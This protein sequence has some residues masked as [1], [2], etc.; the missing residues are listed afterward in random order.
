MA[1]A[2]TLPVS[3]VLLLLFV[4]PA[5]AAFLCYDEKYYP[6]VDQLEET[7]AGFVAHL[8]GRFLSSDNNTFSPLFERPTLIYTKEER[9]KK[10]EVASCR[11]YGCFEEKTRGATNLPPVTLSREEAIALRPV[12][13]NALEIEQKVTASIEY[14]ELIWFG[15][16]FYSGEGTSGVGGVGRYDPTTKTLEIRRPPLLRDS[17]VRPILHDGK[18][19]WLGTFGAYECIG[20]PPKHGLVRYVWDT[21]QLES[22]EG[23]EDGPCGYMVHDLLLQ[24][25]RLWVAT[26]L[27]LSR[28]DR[29]LKRWDHYVPDP[30][31]SPP[32][33][34][35]T[36]EALYTTLLDTLP[37]KFIPGSDFEGYY[38]QLFYTLA[39][40]RPSFL[41]SYV[42]TKPAGRW[43]CADLR[44]LAKETKDFQ[45]LNEEVIQNRPIRSPHFECL[46][47][48]FDGKGSRD[49]GWRDFLLS[50]LELPGNEN[51]HLRSKA[52]EKLKAFSGDLKVGEA[53]VRILKTASRPWY[54]AELLPIILGK[55]SVPYLIEAMDRFKDDVDVLRSIGQA[56]QDTTGHYWDYDRGIQPLPENE[57]GRYVRV[58]SKERFI[59]HWKAWWEAHKS[60]YVDPSVQP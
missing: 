35:T 26:D 7:E 37:D 54:E 20:Y 56:L 3:F 47:D 27:G 46:L 31:A 33:R 5:S 30:D 50:I 19:L 60:E 17:S 34:Q 13:K 12:L 16:G 38:V 32:M 42:K 8:G 9:W 15:I 43:G 28:W 57:A 21:D 59:A 4:S 55:R 25:D 24:G 39:H 11:G 45:T 49:V 29:R 2:Q 52:L 18:Y 53:I 1:I 36:C 14:G 41:K 22:F 58:L 40:F 44:F 48:G 23:K 51:A 6:S 10:G